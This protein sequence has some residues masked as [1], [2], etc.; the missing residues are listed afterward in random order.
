M[1]GQK[2]LVVLPYEHHRVE[3]ADSQRVRLPQRPTAIAMTLISAVCFALLLLV[4]ITDNRRRGDDFTG[5]AAV[6]ALVG[7]LT[8]VAAISLWSELKSRIPQFTQWAPVAPT[9]RASPVMI[10]P[11]ALTIANFQKHI[12]AKYEATDRARGT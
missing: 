6:L 7:F 12:S 3:D 1:I 9:A 10:D 5:I 2:P 11:N 4:M 8:G